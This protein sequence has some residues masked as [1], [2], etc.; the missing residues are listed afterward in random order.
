[1]A[2]R[3]KV[4]LVE[5]DGLERCGRGADL[6]EGGVDGAG[7]ADVGIRH[8]GLEGGTGVEGHE[9]EEERHG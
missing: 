1:M 8:D 2:V 6:R 9:E 7:P 5:L 3:C 4:E